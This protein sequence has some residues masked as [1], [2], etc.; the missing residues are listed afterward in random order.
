[1]AVRPSLETAR[2]GLEGQALIASSDDG[3][4]MGPQT[5]AWACEPFFTTKGNGKGSGR[6]LSMIQGFARR[7]G[8]APRFRSAPFHGTRVELWQP[9]ARGRHLTAA[10]ETLP[11]SRDQSRILLVDDVP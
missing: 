10:A 9:T 11:A 1:M 4:G 6:G 7:S 8:G 5:I 2:P 3:V